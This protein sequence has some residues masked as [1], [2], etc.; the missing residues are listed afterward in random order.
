MARLS[1]SPD[2]ASGTNF[3]VVVTFVIS[4]GGEK[5]TLGINELKGTD[6]FSSHF[7][8]LSHI[9]SG[10]VARWNNMVVGTYMEAGNREKERQGWGLL[11][12]PKFRTHPV[13][14]FNSQ[15]GLELQH[16]T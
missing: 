12:I 4:V 2:L 14:F 6:E 11:P 5:K 8:V 13:R 9:V 1:H 16:S 10:P 3:A 15:Q 7:S